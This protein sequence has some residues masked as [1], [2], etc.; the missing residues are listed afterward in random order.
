M[1]FHFEHYCVVILRVTKKGVAME[2]RVFL[3]KSGDEEQFQP[4]LTIAPQQPPLAK[5]SA[6]NI[7]SLEDED[8]P[9]SYANFSFDSVSQYEFRRFSEYQYGLWYKCG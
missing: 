8:A 1:P 2:L 5:S 4:V 6:T 9:Q 3:C 7:V